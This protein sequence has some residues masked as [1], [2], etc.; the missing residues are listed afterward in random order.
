[1]LISYNHNKYFEKA[2]KSVL[3]QKTSYKFKIHIFDDASTDGTSILVRQYAD[4]YRELIRAYIAEA[5]QGAE[6]ALMN[7]YKS[8]DTKYCILLE[9]DDYWC[10]EKKLHMQIQALE[11]HPECSFAAH[12]TSFVAL[13]ERSR[14]YHDNYLFVMNKK[15]IKK[16]I[17]KYSD[18]EHVANGGYIPHISS[19]LVKTELLD[20]EKV[21]NKEAILFDSN[22]YFYLLIKGPYYYI[23]KTM[24]IYQRTG[25]GICSG[26]S[27]L[28]FL[29]GF[30][31][32]STDFNIETNFIIADKIFQECQLQMNHRM[33]LYRKYKKKTLAI[34]KSIDAKSFLSR[35]IEYFKKMCPKNKIRTEA[36]NIFEIKQKL[37][38]DKY[39]FLCTAGIGDTFL[40]CALHESLERKLNG[41]VHLLVLPSHE[42]LIKMYNFTD[43]TVI[44][45]NESVLESLSDESPIPKR[46]KVFVAHP[47]CHRELH[48]FFQSIYLQTSSIRFYPWFLEFLGL[49]N[50]TKLKE[51]VSFPKMSKNFKCQC[52]QIASLDKI[53][54]LCPE[55]TSV[56]SLPELFW[57]N[58]AKELKKKGFTVISNAK[59]KKKMITGTIYIE[60]DTEEAVAL[61]FAC[62]S[63]YSLRSG[64]CDAIYAKGKN[65]YVYYPSQK[66]Y[67]I[68]SLNKLF[69]RTDI[70]EEV[71]NTSINQELRKPDRRLQT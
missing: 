25:S 48:K 47:H 38:P 23:D 39:Y 20:I 6:T 56:S 4:K 37:L 63:V 54:L 51:P 24:S 14:E 12:N 58:K 26:K 11:K 57:R 8:V 33:C 10:N 43:Y 59:Y 46:G 44:C 69:E 65:L 35:F 41:K 42:F 60:M 21:I 52:E 67:F 49:D 1:L 17:I 30:I 5:N 64:F 34:G 22:Q 3:N 32:F 19:R 31:R 66:S 28:V 15:L 13:D 61:A 71:I 68:Y 53:V 70:N 36:I 27:P 45:L 16:R 18:I 7:A 29:N 55:A 62:H 2:I 40:I 50:N 9:T